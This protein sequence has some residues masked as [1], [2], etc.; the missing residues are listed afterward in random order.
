MLLAL[1][2]NLITLSGLRIDILIQIKLETIV[3]SGNAQYTVTE[4]RLHSHGSVSASVKNCICT[5]MY[6]GA[7]PG[8]YQICTGTLP[9]VKQLSM[10]LT[11]TSTKW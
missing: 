5:Q 3:Q 10:N 7:C 1:I 11:V 2:T 6:S 8:F 4:Y 9:R